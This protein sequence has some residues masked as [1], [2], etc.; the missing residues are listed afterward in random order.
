MTTALAILELAA[1]ISLTVALVV[2]HA[3]PTGLSPLTDPVSRYALTRFRAGYT[4]AAV[5]AAVAGAAAAVVLSTLPAAGA[6]TALLW[7]F[8]AARALIPLFPMD[9]PGTTSS[10]SGRIHRLLA[11][12]AFA[13]VTAAAFVAAGPLADAGFRL[14]GTISTICAILMA[15][16][17]VGVV[18]GTAG[19]AVR[20]AF[21]LFER[22]IYLG[23]IVWFA[24]MSIVFLTS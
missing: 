1:T 4:V 6:A 9:E 11:I 7:V 18:A 15:I 17:S 5:S 14:T 23:F 3:A 19:P 24:T 2:L 21:G 10:R 20:R 22:L 12:V 13:T 16:G 8:A